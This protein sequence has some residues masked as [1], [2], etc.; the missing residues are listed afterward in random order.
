MKDINNQ[1]S[2]V[3][4]AT[5]R[6]LEQIDL[7][8]L[9]PTFG[10]AHLAYW[11]DKTSDVADMRRQEVMLT[12]ALLYSQDYPGSSYKGNNRLK[13][14]IEALLSFWCKNQY[15]DGSLDE[16]YKGE[17]AFAAAAFS[18]HAVARTIMIMKEYLSKETTLLATEKLKK[19]AHWLTQHNDL[20][21]ANHQAVGVAALYWA[22]EMLQNDVFRNNAYEKLLSILDVQTK[23]FWFPEVGNMDIGYTFLTV[24]FI[25]MAMDFSND[26]RHI[27]P[28]RRAF[29][30]ACEW[31]HPDLTVGSEYGVCHNPYLSRIA[32]ILMS[33][34][35][36]RAVYLRNRLEQGT[37]GF[38]GYATALA[39]DL[40][41]LRY[42]YQPL[43]AY[44]YDKK[45]PFS[46]S[47]K[48]EEA[49]FSN[50]DNEVHIYNE[51]ALGRFSHCGCNGIF[52]ACAGGL[53][54][55]FG[56]TEGETFSDYGYAISFDN[57]YST[58][59]TYNRNIKI[60][61]TD[62]DLTITSHIF[63]VK[64][65]MP[66]FWARVI[67]YMACS[68]SLGSKIARKGIDIIRKKKG[69]AIN[70]SCANLNS[71]KSIFKL[72]REV[73][74]KKDHICIKDKLIFKKPVQREKIF[75]LESSS[76][77]L[78]NSQPLTLHLSNIPATVNYLEIVK[79]YY[80]GDNW[81]LGK[82]SAAA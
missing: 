11:R 56:K 5:D 50:P 73:S 40:R 59:Y 57:K 76:D 39:D 80:P 41:L 21:K 55:L 26:W 82:I 66:S 42:A 19:T 15:P 1:I 78:I 71:R 72:T 29:D 23:E 64:K 37:S 60:Q 14:A 32:I 61:K 4:N 12:F 63:P 8:V 22:G 34:F 6:M 79:L 69:T 45:T 17:R 2:F 65:F 49:T 3:I 51:S 9:S 7:D 58:N 36:N 47:L 20:F 38:R 44:G 54:R 13:R 27:E 68:T 10:C 43:L 33:K 18:T 74:F 31:I 30:F 77:G 28:F 70:Q 16:W 67:L 48:H 35:S 75:F 24:E 52:A 81:S 62:N 25:L 53:I 46:L